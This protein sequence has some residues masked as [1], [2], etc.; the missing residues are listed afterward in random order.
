VLILGAGVVRTSERRGRPFLFRAAGSAGAR[1][2]LEVYASTH[3]VDGVPDGV[4]WYGPVEHALVQIGPAAAGDATT[5]IVTGVP[6]RTGWRYAE[7]GFRHIYWDAGTLLAQLTNAATSAGQTPQ[8]F[9]LFPDATVRDLVNA[10]GVHEFPVTLLTLGG[11][12]SATELT[13]PAI[14]GMLTPFELPLCTEAQQAG[15][16]TE[17]GAPWPTA[18][19]LADPPPSPTTE[20]VILRRGSQRTMDRTARLPR[21]LL[22]WLMRAAM[23]GIDVP[24]WVIVHAVDGVAPGVYRWPDLDNA[25]PSKATDEDARRAETFRI[26]LDQGSGWRRR[27]CGRRRDRG[28]QGRRPK[29]SRRAACRRAG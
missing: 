19:A 13:G 16:R 2:P 18:T 10:D 15:E 17:L 28:R 9:T 20:Q 29:L 25:L 14:V 5:V 26:C 4:H 11:G 27:I 12:R 6:W 7:R 8:L 3:G 23:R 21:H 22:E 24:H 1:F